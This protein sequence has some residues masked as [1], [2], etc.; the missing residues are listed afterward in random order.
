MREF[1]KRNCLGLQKFFL[2]IQSPL[3]FVARTVGS[4][5]YLPGTGTLGWRAW[6]R[7]GT[8]QSWDIPPKLLSITCGWGTS[9]FHACTPLISLGGCGFFNT[10][11]VRLLFNL[12]SDRSEGWL[13][14]LSVVIL[15]CLWEEMSHVCLCLHLDRK[16]DWILKKSLEKYVSYFNFYSFKMH[17]WTWV[18]IYICVFNLSLP[19]MHLSP[20]WSGKSHYIKGKIEWTEQW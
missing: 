8:P 11:V 18:V 12:I 19:N 4:R 15:M 7:D 6:C 13:F 1:F 5:T 17:Y 20:G 3:V 10:G 9:Q 14:Y 2:P 16:L